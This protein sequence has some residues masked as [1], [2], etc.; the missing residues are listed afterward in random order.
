MTLV[1]PATLS[2][3]PKMAQTIQTAAGVIRVSAE[4]EMDEQVI[5]D[6]IRGIMQASMRHVM[7][8]VTNKIVA[9]TLPNNP[10]SGKS[11]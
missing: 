7:Q 2:E 6:A 9:R 3:N 11:P 1:F 10:Q 8:T 4:I 5:I